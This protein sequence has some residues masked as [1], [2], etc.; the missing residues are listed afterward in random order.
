MDQSVKEELK[1]LA[2][3]GQA[4]QLALRGTSPQ[5]RAFLQ[6]QGFTKDRRIVVQRFVYKLVGACWKGK[7]A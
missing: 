4:L 1:Q 6:L 7:N 5:A 3:L 2:Q